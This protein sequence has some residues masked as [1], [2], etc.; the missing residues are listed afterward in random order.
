MQPN[1]GFPVRIIIISIK[2]GLFHELLIFS[3]RVVTINWLQSRNTK[4]NTVLYATSLNASRNFEGTRILVAFN[5]NI[6][7]R[8]ISKQCF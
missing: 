5:G 3:G 7:A 4:S 6:Q 8:R 2:T 1:W